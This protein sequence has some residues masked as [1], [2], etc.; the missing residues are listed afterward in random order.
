MA[1][2]GIFINL[3]TLTQPILILW[4]PAN[5]LTLLQQSHRFGSGSGFGSGSIPLT[6]GSGSG[7]MD[8]DPDSDTDWNESTNVPLSKLRIKTKPKRFDVFQNPKVEC[9]YLFQKFGNKTKTFWCV[10]ISF[11]QKQNISIFSKNFGT[12]PKLFDVLQ[13]FLAKAKR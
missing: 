6:S 13:L 2:T 8:P 9:F 7:K 12:K 5:T 10:P 1:S 3:T 11:L 4:A